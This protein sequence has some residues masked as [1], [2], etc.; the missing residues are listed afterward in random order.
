ML[1]KAILFLVIVSPEQVMID[2]ELY[3]DLRHCT[4]IS[5]A[6]NG[7]EPNRT[8]NPSVESVCV[9]MKDEIKEL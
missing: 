6:I 3:G 1:H 7:Y 2:Y 8:G 9:E 4:E 5:N